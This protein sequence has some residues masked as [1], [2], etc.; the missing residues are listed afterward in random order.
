MEPLLDYRIVPQPSWLT[1][2][3][4][5]RLITVAAA[6]LAALVVARVVALAAAADQLANRLWV[7][8]VDEAG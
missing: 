7:T 4:L 8:P 6:L 3:P 2:S 1:H 5:P